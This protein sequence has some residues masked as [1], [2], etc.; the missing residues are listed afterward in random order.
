MRWFCFLVVGAA[1]AGCGMGAVCVSTAVGF[2]E[3][4][5]VLAGL[6]LACAG[7]HILW[8]IMSRLVGVDRVSSMDVE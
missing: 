5:Q 4:G 3:A 7:G 1:C 2:K 6:G 8:W